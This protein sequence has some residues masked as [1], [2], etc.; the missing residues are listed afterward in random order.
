MRQ[1]Q[2]QYSVVKVEQ[3]VGNG[4]LPRSLTGLNTNTGSEV[5]AGESQVA[6]LSGIGPASD[7]GNSSAV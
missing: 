2:D 4:P 3:E 1:A 7:Q 5:A 6:S